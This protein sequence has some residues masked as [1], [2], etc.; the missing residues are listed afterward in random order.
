MR[1]MPQHIHALHQLPAV[2]EATEDDRLALERDL[3]RVM[4]TA[5]GNNAYA[6]IAATHSEVVACKQAIRT[7]LTHEVGVV[8]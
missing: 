1:C 8:Q 7:M 5:N 3:N 4:R 6:S 2:E